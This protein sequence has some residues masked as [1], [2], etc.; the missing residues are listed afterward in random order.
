MVNRYYRM[1][2]VPIANP[3]PRK[4]ISEEIIITIVVKFSG[5]KII[6]NIG[7]NGCKH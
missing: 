2:A 3:G 4:Q 5:Y 6:P 1:L 7:T